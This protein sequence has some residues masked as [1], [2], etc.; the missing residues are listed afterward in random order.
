LQ[1]KYFGDITKI[2]GA[3]VPIVDV[4]TGGSPCQ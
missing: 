1:V 4:I 3:E 2:N